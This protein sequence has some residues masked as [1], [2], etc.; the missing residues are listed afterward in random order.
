MIGTTFQSASDTITV[1]LPANLPPGA[2]TGTVTVTFNPKFSGANVTKTVTLS[3]TVTDPNAPTGFDLSTTLQSGNDVIQGQM[4]NAALK[5]F[6]KVQGGNIGGFKTR[7]LVSIDGAPEIVSYDGLI[8]Y[9]P[10]DGQLF[11]LV[12]PIPITAHSIT[13]R[14][15][16][17][18][19]NTTVEVNEGNNTKTL[20]KTFN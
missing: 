7:M 3:A 14:V 10:G 11:S 1:T 13:F 17:D 5:V 8:V 20:T 12:H 9:A 2:K 15:I 18:P 4:R 19:D 6:G 16:T